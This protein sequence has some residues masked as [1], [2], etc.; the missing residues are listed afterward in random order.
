[1]EDSNKVSAKVRAQHEHFGGVEDD[2]MRARYALLWFGARCSQIK[3]LCLKNRECRR[4]GDV[5]G[6]DGR[7]ATILVSQETLLELGYLLFSQRNSGS[8]A[9]DCRV[10]IS[11][12]CS[13]LRK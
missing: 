6:A 1:M 9:E 3:L 8:I 10:D 7:T 4:V 13:N 5:Y 12:E 11:V 2:L